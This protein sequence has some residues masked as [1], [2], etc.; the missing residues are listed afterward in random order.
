[1]Q[2]PTIGAKI[3]F[4]EYMVPCLMGKETTP[5]KFHG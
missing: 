2:A 4:A 1:L 5:F 3:L